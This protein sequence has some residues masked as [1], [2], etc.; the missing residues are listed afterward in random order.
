VYSYI[1]RLGILDGRA[2][3]VFCRLLAIYEFLSYSKKVELHRHKQD[4]ASGESLSKVPAFDWQK[5][6]P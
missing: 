5:K 3:L 4:L 1:F 6:S 2:G